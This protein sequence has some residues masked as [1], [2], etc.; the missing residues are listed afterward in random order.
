MQ[1]FRA[2]HWT[3]V[4]DPYGRVGKRLKELKGMGIQL[5][6]L[7]YKPENLRVPTD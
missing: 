7:E 2:N 1:I 5:K 3:E 6:D 4:R